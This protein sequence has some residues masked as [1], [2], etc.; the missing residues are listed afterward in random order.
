MRAALAL[1]AGLAL[2]ACGD[3]NSSAPIDAPPAIDAG[4][5]AA[6]DAPID[7]PPDA[8]TFTTFVIDQIQNQ[9]TA[10]ATPAPYATFAPLPDPDSANPAAYAPLFP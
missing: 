8:S 4:P 2:A 7:A 6:I 3:D 10:T 9:T 1:A 5:D